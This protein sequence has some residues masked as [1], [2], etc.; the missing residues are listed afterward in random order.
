MSIRDFIDPSFSEKSS[1]FVEQDFTVQAPLFL[2]G[3]ILETEIEASCNIYG[4]G[5]FEIKSVRICFT[6]GE[7]DAL[8]KTVIDQLKATIKEKIEESYWKQIKELSAEARAA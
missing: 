8:P 2:F 5:K 3:E 1:W 4:S 6:D 7:T